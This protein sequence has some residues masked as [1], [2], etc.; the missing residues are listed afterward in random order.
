MKM[1]IN[2]FQTQLSVIQDCFSVMKEW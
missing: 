2:Y 1:L